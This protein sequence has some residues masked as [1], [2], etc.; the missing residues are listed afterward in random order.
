MLRPTLL[1]LLVDKCSSARLAEKCWHAAWWDVYPHAPT[2]LS[3]VLSAFLFCLISWTGAMSNEAFQKLVRGKAGVNRGGRAR[4]KLRGK[5]G[6]RPS[7]L[8]AGKSDAS[9]VDSGAMMTAMVVRI[10]SK[11]DAA[12]RH[13]PEQE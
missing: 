10:P 12:S 3:A 4:R 13:K 8:H 1:L 11:E 5:L 6:A 7:F 2:F 9:V